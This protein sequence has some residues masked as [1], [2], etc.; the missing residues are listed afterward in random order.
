MNRSGR[1]L[2]PAP[3]I[4]LILATVLVPLVLLVRVSLYE[5]ARGRG[6]FAPGTITVQNYA[7]A[8]DA[9]GLQIAGFTALFG[10][11][12]TVLT[13]LL[14][15]PL[16]L[17]LWSLPGRQQSLALAL[18]LLPKA[19]GLLATMFG[20]QRGLA[21]GFWAAVIGEVYLILPYAVL[22][23]FA[24]L[25]E[26]EH[27]WIAAARGLGA[28]RFQAFRRV[29]W[30]LSLPGVLLSSLLAMIWGTGGF[31]GPLFLGTPDDMTLS[32][33]LHRQAFEYSRWPRAA[34]DAVG[35]MVLTV[36]LILIISGVGRKATSRPSLR[37]S[38][39]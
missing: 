7:D 27:Q 28:S 25:R 10:G 30:P 34:A 5:P 11:T 17:F 3:A 36:L 18:V 4:L 33:E 21:R 23:L 35:L 9:D 14:G 32:V 8:F 39:Q 26:L 31:L 16:A 2:L 29:I 24:Q 6:F 20:L 38:A 22:V 15:Y 19:A 13:L 12:V 37:T 1:W